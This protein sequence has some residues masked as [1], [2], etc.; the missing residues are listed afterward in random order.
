MSTYTQSLVPSHR[1]TTTDFRKAK[2]RGQL[3]KLLA[4]ITGRSNQLLDL[5]TLAKEN[6]IRSR[7]YAGTRTVNI[8]E[9]KGSEGRTQDFDHNFNPL[10]SHNRARWI[11]I[12]RAWMFGISLPAIDLIKVKDVYLVRDG[13]HRVSVARYMGCDFLDANVT[14]WVLEA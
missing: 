14:E 4:T 6:N 10:K 11:N 8:D 3:G 9:I 2:F 1:V 12:A 13:H 5:E 7:R